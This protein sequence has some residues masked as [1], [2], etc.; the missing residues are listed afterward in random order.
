MSLDTFIDNPPLW[1]NGEG[2][3]SEIILSSRLC[4]ARN[5]EPYKFSGMANI[6]ELNDIFDFIVTRVVEGIKPS[7]TIFLLSQFSDLDR[8][9]LAERHLISDALIKETNGRGV[10]VFDREVL[11]FMINEEDHLRIQCIVSGLDIENAYNKLNELDDSFSHLLPYAFSHKF[12]YLTASPTNVGT[13]L[14]ASVFL[15]LPALVHS[16]K[17]RKVLEDVTQRGF[18]ARGFYGEGSQ[19][20]GNFFQISN[21]TTLGRKEEEIIEGL[22]KTAL[23]VIE[24]ENNARDILLKN[25]KVQLEDKIWRA[26]SILRSARL[27]STDEFINLCSAVRLGIGIGVL[28]DVKISTL[29]KLLIYVQPAHLQRLMGETSDSTECDARR[30]LYVRENL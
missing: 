3:Y 20:E 12:G 24:S 7:P 14:R 11:S 29:N 5:L 18:L 10:G 9:F 19:I 27:L 25:A 17:I 26:F 21:Q 16:G 13:G 28:K 15:H 8:K 23:Q 6:K 4:F 2:P 30:A 1:T 22:H